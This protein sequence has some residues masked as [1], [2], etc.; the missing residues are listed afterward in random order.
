MALQPLSSN[1]VRS[2]NSRVKVEIAPIE[3]ARVPLANPLKNAYDRL[4]HA[5]CEDDSET[6]V[7][8]L[9]GSFD[10][11]RRLD[12]SQDPALLKLRPWTL[13]PIRTA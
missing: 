13:S 12:M 6:I 10:G 8:L 4:Y 2:Q 5:L 11:G 7:E 9:D 1:V 3:G